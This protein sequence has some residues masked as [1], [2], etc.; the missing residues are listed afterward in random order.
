M[1]DAGGRPPIRDVAQDVLLVKVRG[2]AKKLAATASG[3]LKVL[4]FV[5]AQE[6]KG[7]TA[8]S[9]A[10]Q[11][12]LALL[13]C[14]LWWK[15]SDVVEKELRIMARGSQVPQCSSMAR[16]NHDDLTLPASSGQYS[17]IRLLRNVPPA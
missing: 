3:K 9:H 2:T 5:A 8:L 11:V 6:E 17:S 12:L 7:E 4:S 1:Q 13:E 15:L 14:P 16:A 10:R